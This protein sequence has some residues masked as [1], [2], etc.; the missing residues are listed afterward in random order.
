MYGQHFGWMCLSVHFSE[1][2]QCFGTL[3]SPRG[4]RWSESLATYLDLCKRNLAS[5]RH[6]ALFI[7]AEILK[8][9]MRTCCLFYH[10]RISCLPL[11]WGGWSPQSDLETEVGQ[12]AMVVYSYNPAVWRQRQ[13][14][15]KSQASLGSTRPCRW[16]KGEGR[17]EKQEK[18][19]RRG[20][21]DDHSAEHWEM[22]SL[23]LDTGPSATIGTVLLG[24][25]NRHPGFLPSWFSW[26]LSGLWLWLL[27]LFQSSVFLLLRFPL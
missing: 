23:D 13:G 11:P 21:C 7:R 22:K 14:D 9:F 20:Y 25:L 12:L 24:G 16:G 1:H 10:L 17:K 26:L 19:R 5:T 4:T 6:I 3:L 27:W 2:S 8:P 18:E 15:R